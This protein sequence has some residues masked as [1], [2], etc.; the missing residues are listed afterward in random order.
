MESDSIRK[1]VILEFSF[2]I[3]QRCVTVSAKVGQE[4]GACN[5]IVEYIQ[6]VVKFLAVLEPVVAF[7][8]H[9]DPFIPIST[10]AFQFPESLQSARINCY[11]SILVSLADSCVVTLRKGPRP[12]QPLNR[13][14]WL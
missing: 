12:W 1:F 7:A 2:W 14:G 4:W 6:R 11:R 13:E 10:F 8:D 9:S 5:F 3:S